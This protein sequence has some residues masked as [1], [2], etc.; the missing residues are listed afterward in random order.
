MV[1]V[2]DANK[3]VVYRQCI[4]PESYCE[5]A[6]TCMCAPLQSFGAMAS[7]YYAIASALEIADKL[8]VMPDRKETH[9]ALIRARADHGLIYE[10]GN[11]K[12]LNTEVVVSAAPQ[13]I[14]A[15]F[16]NSAYDIQGQLA[17]LGIPAVSITSHLEQHPLGR[18]EWIK[19]FGAFFNK[20]KEADAIFENIKTKYENISQ[21]Q[22]DSSV[23]RP[24]V[25]VG[26]YKKDAW[27]A[28]GGKGYFARYLQ[29]CGADYV[30][31]HDENTG[32]VTINF[33][34]AYMAGMNADIIIYIRMGSMKWEDVLETEPMLHDW[35]A[36]LNGQV[37]SN[38]AQVNEVGRNNYWEQGVIEPH[39]ILSDL[40]HMA[41]PD[42]T[43]QPLVY[44]R[45]CTT[46]P[47]TD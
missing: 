33:E 46:H 16:T 43:T 4:A 19:L 40:Q 25:L 7:P 15:S 44:F 34:D 41:Y 8:T 6:D 26:Y 42:T 9:S 24:R 13:A 23:R 29:D 12:M 10:V 39:I 31:K 22:P 30:F 35:K 20:E 17:Q 2:Y 38:D 11:Y 32:N 21:H 18:A 36:V 14:F 27:V 45:N 3:Q 28:P 37:Y 1:R 5:Q 47:I